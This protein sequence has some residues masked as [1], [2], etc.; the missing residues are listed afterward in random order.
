MRG[1]HPDP[2]TFA[3][4]ARRYDTIPVYRE[5]LADLETPVSC[6]LKVGDEPYSLL[7]ESVEGGE[8]LARYSILGIGA[9]AVFT[10][11]GRQITVSDERGRSRVWQTRTDPL[12]ELQTLQ[13]SYRQAPLQG[14]PPFAGGFVGYMGYD[15][16]RFFERIPDKNPDKTGLP[17]MVF[18]APR[19]IV[20]FD[21]TERR[22]RIIS[23]ARVRR[24]RSGS[25]AYREAARRIDAA[26]SRLFRSAKLR[27][28]PVP[29]E[30]PTGKLRID[31]NFTR[32]GFRKAVLEAQE[33]I[34]K[35]DIFQVVLSQAFSTPLK[36]EPFEVYRALRSINPSPYMFYLNFG[37]LKVAGSSPEVHVKCTAGVASLRPI[38]G[39]RRRGRDASEDKALE[40][41]LLADPKERAE[42]LMLV[43]LGRNDLG[44]VCG[45]G[46]VKVTEFSTVERYSHVM[47]LV[48]NVE[49]RLARG[50]NG[51]DLLRATFPAGTISGAPK[52]RAMEIID[53]LENRRRGLYSG[54]VG[55]FSHTGDMDTCIAI[56]TIVMSGGRA[57]AQAGAGIVADSD[58][59]KEYE[60]TV[61]KAKALFRAI[62]A[63]AGGMAR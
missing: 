26:A 13:R 18:V 9:S 35:G 33:H 34:R 11:K 8:S 19:I 29:I 46:S 17:D 61:N 3:R 45:Y 55:Y 31:S 25:A 6:F 21:H 37:P 5:Y 2:R 58:P 23:S 20:V 40:R 27:N 24:G 15:T 22:I 32:A 1:Y 49:G 39:T 12:R 28:L 43:D 52:V 51:Y 36:A 41:E 62:E 42:H 56:R 63:A 14:M 47:H 10:S 50:R 60:E 4:L 16:V 54:V 48:S 7:L 57:T 38:A 44:R 30:R 53:R 59:A